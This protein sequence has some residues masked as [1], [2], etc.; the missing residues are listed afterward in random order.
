MVVT[1]ITMGLIG[2]GTWMVFRSKPASVPIAPQGALARASDLPVPASPRPATVLPPEP[3]PPAP[4]LPAREVYFKA[5]VAG[6]ERGLDA[7][8][9]A[10]ADAKS[11]RGRADPAYLRTLQALESTYTERLSRHQRAIASRP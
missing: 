10:L 6:E 9:K 7:V 8:R 2:M 11:G 5:M 3:E 4:G 1:A